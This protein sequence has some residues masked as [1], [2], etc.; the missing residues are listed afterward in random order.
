MHGLDTASSA[1]SALSPSIL[2]L[3]EDILDAGLA[4]HCI[5]KARVLHWLGFKA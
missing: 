2:S 1:L 3:R 5:Q 4:A